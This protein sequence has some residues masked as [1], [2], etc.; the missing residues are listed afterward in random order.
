MA[1]RRCAIHR[2]EPETLHHFLRNETRVSRVYRRCSLILHACKLGRRLEADRARVVDVLSG[3]A[4]FT[5]KAWNGREVVAAPQ[6][7]RTVFRF[8]RAITSRDRCVPTRRNLDRRKKNVDL[9]R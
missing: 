1:R 2:G 8:Y 9:K 7:A 3:E 6:P 4:I 5:E